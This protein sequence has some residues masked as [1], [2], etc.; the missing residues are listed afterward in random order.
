ML[1]AAGA[2]YGGIRADLR[3]AHEKADRALASADKAHKRID[4]HLDFGRRS[5]DGAG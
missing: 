3:S 2:V 1:L 5:G 4:A